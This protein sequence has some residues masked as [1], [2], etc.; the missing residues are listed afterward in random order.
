MPSYSYERKVYNYQVRRNENCWVTLDEKK[1]F[2]NLAE[3]VEVCHMV[4]AEI[5]LERLI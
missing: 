1:Y 2:E 5:R 4:S 3:L